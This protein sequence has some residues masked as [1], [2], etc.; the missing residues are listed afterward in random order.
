M[1]ST[2]NSPSV[3]SIEVSTSSASVNQNAKDRPE[4][5]SVSPQFARDFLHLFL[6]QDGFVTDV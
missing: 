6:K 2:R 3:A 5:G 4:K 1:A